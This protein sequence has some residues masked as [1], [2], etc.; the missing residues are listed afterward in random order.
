MPI[1]SVLDTITVV[2]QNDATWLGFPDTPSGYTVD[3]T[4]GDELK[5]EF[6]SLDQLE[7]LMELMKQSGMNISE[8][9]VHDSIDN[10]NYPPIK[11]LI[12][13]RKDGPKLYSLK[14]NVT[15][16]DGRQTYIDINVGFFINVKRIMQ[17]GITQP[18]PDDFG[19]QVGVYFINPTFP[20]LV[21][22]KGT[23]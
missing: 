3:A 20:Q 16:K 4:L 14:G 17:K 5:L 2:T 19:D 8:L 6:S 7:A 12:Y 13:L 10:W 9:N 22:T 21:W 15:T 18:V 1:N 23:N 11:R